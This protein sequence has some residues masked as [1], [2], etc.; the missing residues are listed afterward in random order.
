MQKNNDN[1]NTRGGR[2]FRAFPPNRRSRIK[3][4]RLL[5]KRVLIAPENSQF[6]LEDYGKIFHVYKM[7]F[8][9]AKI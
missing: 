2:I 4:I 5:V 8:L 1:Y 3:S 9:Y 7:T 6:Q